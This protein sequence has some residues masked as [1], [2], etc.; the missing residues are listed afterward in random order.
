[1]DLPPEKNIGYTLVSHHCAPGD[2]AE[3]V[4]GGEWIMYPPDTAIE[5]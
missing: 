5:D 4:V 2:H 1:M 3:V